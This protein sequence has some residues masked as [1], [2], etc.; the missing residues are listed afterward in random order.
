MATVKEL[1][2]ENN[3]TNNIDAKNISIY[4]YL[5]KPY[6]I[7]IPRYQREYSWEFKNVKA[8][9]N[10]VKEDYYIG[11]IIEYNNVEFMNREIVDGQQR[12]ITIF[13][14]LIALQHSI[15]ANE[16]KHEITELIS[17]GK[18]CKLI[19]KYRISSDGSNILNFFKDDAQLPKELEE[20]I[21]EVRIFKFIKK[22]LASYDEEKLEDLYFRI[23]NSTFVNIS[24]YK[25][26]KTAHE[27]FVNVNTKGKPLEKI[28]ILK[29]QLFKYL[30]NSDASDEYKEKWQVML[31]KIP[32]KEYD[33]YCSDVYLLTQFK[34]IGISEKYKT[35][36]TIN[37]N[38]T[39]LI[40][41]INSKEEAERIF[42][43][44]TGEDKEDVLTI[45]SA[46]KKYEIEKLKEDYFK[47][48]KASLGKLDSMWKLYK[49]TNFKQSDIMLVSLLLNKVNFINKEVNYLCVFIQY[50]F[51]FELCRSFMNISPAH[52]SNSFKQ[53]AARICNCNDN[54]KIKEI[55]KRFTKDLKVDDSKLR[56]SLLD[57]KFNKNKGK[58]LKLIIMMAED[59]FIPN[60]FLEH[61]ICQ[62]TD[63]EEDKSSIWKIGNLIPVIND[64][65]GDKSVDI[66]LDL[67]NKDKVPDIGIKN[68]LQFQFSKEN[69]KDK[70]TERGEKI[71]DQFLNNL[72][73]CYKR[74]MKG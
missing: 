21:N 28:E 54:L 19:L 23:K 33:T 68:F 22:E 39:K 26:E 20:K 51:M 46:V 30:V 71:V 55:L 1:V 11:N 66:K 31:E 5:K 43:F 74:I 13:L 64:K 7:V 27:M 48:V 52:Y 72:N 50:I 12:I 47:N 25:N 70:I 61:F 56:K 9:I 58:T 38:S 8:L 34:K 53:A 57:E 40:E 2:R 41:S 14:I 44:M 59:V 35:N 49:E 4:E 16:I 18:D 3:I 69:Y 67:Y 45:Y 60:L 36:G 63:V 24:F 29:S 42:K 17:T 73:I 15:N 6:E 10:D 65:Y 62:K 32:K 37:E